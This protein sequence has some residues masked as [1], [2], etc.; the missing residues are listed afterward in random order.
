MRRW[1]LDSQKAD[2]HISET[3]SEKNSFND[4]SAMMS[5]NSLKLSVFNLI[6]YVYYVFTCVSDKLRFLASS[7]RSA[8]TTYWLFS[9]ECSN[10][11]IWLGLKDVRILFGL[12]NGSKNSGKWGPRIIRGNILN[13][14]YSLIRQ[15]FLFP[16]RKPNNDSHSHQSLSTV[17]ASI[18]K[19]PI[20]IIANWM[21]RELAKRL[22]LFQNLISRNRHLKILKKWKIIS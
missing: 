18:R 21:I 13:I 12:L 15:N 6:K 16:F 8:P 2:W 20:Y 14:K 9:K 10:F 7:F 3:F 5:N 17:R 11:S 4:S 19:D 1:G 22:N